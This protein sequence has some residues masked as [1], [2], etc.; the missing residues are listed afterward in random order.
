[1]TM[2]AMDGTTAAADGTRGRWL[3][4]LSLA[5]AGVAVA[6]VAAFAGLKSLAMLAVGVGALAVGLAAAFAFLSRRGVLRWL[7]L[8]VFALAPIV[9]IV[10]YAFAGLLWVALVSAAAWPGAM[11]PGCGTSPRPG[12]PAQAR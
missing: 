7:A 2:P 1:M 10:V 9:V 8:A 12:N 3:A 4:R 6:I 5:L 11:A